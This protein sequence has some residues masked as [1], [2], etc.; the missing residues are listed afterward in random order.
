MEDP[1]SFSALPHRTAALL[2]PSRLETFPINTIAFTQAQRSRRKL[3][4]M[5]EGVYLLEVGGRVHRIERIDVLG[6]W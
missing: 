3:K 2:L 5:Y 4:E 1:D 6:A